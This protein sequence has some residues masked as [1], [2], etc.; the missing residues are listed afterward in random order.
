MPEL[1]LDNSSPPSHS[2]LPTDPV[3]SDLDLLIALRKVVRS[4]TIHPISNFVSYHRLSSSFFASSSHLSSI[5]IPKNVQEAFG[6]PSWK[7]A[8]VEEVKALKKME[9]GN[10]LPY[11]KVKEL[12]DVSGSFQ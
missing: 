1:G 10:L 2:S 8:V 11:R 6:D 12:W 4:C 5:E 3:P 9:H 7:T